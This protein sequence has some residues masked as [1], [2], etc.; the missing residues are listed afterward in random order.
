[1]GFGPNEIFEKSIEERQLPLQ[2]GDLLLV[3]TDG[4]VEAK[5][6]MNEEF[7][8]PYVCDVLKQNSKASAEE[9]IQ[10]IMSAVVDFCDGQPQE[11]D[12]ALMAIRYTGVEQTEDTDEAGLTADS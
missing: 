11:D 6:S 7:E 1:L 3:Y 10:A 4:L 8:L 12:I 5:N 2:V 9:I